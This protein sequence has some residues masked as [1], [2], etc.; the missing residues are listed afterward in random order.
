MMVL[1]L[2]LKMGED[3]PKCLWKTINTV[4][5]DHKPLYQAS[6]SFKSCFTAELLVW[7]WHSFSP[8]IPMGFQISEV[9]VLS[10]HGIV[11]K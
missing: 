11:G 3:S 8:V 4:Q 7:H 10:S 2:D 1:K 9:E 6:V 5:V